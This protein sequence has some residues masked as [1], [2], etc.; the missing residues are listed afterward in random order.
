[1]MFQRKIEWNPSKSFT[2]T[3]K[4]THFIDKLHVLNE[5]DNSYKIIRV[6]VVDE[7]VD[8]PTY[9]ASYS[10]D[11]K[12]SNIIKNLDVRSGAFPEDKYFDSTV[13]QDLND[14]IK[15]QDSKLSTRDLTKIKDASKFLNDEVNKAI[16]KYKQAVEEANKK[17]AKKEGE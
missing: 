12:I 1:M 16:L 14:Q 8:L 13:L 15:I 7:E 17:L 11:T 4:F 6:S 3:R 2:S 9:A 10:E 5:K